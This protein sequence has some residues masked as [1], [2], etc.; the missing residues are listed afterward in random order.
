MARK[1]LAALRGMVDQPSTFADE[2]FGFHAQQ[3]VEKALKA[4]LDLREEAYPKTHDLSH[5]LAA[6]ES[7][8]ERCDDYWTLVDLSVFAV[9]Y[10]YEAFAEPSTPPLERAGIITA[11]S[12]VLSHVEGLRD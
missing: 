7:L 12:A 1:D 9:Q 8:G 5:L 2:V 4:W 3:A 6:L 11:V 10:R